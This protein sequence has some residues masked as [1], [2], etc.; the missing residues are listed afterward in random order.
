MRNPPELLDAALQY[1]LNYNPPLPVI[2]EDSLC[3]RFTHPLTIYDTHIDRRLALKRVKLVPTFL[4]DLAKAV[5]LAI[6][7]ATS[8]GIGLPSVEGHDFPTPESFNFLRRRTLP[9]DAYGITHLYRNGI[10]QSACRIASMLSLHPTAATWSTAVRM[11]I[12][13]TLRNEN[14]YTLVE[15]CMPE[16]LAP[17]K[18]VDEDEGIYHVMVDRDAWE[19]LSDDDRK[20]LEDMRKKFPSMAL[21]QMF[22]PRQETEDML[23][24][25]SALANMDTFPE[26]NP[27]TVLKRWPLNDASFTLPPDAVKTSWEMT[28]ASW[29]GAPGL[30]QTGDLLKSPVRPAFPLRRS[31]RTTMAKLKAAADLKKTEKRPKREKKLETSPPLPKTAL[32]PKWPNVGLPERRDLPAIDKDMT[33]SIIQ[34]AW[35][36]ALKWD[37]SFIIFHCGTFE[38]IAFRH[39][40]SQTLF[41]SDLIDITQCENPMYSKVQIGLFI[42]IINDVRDR[43]RQLI[44][45]EAK[46]MPKK[47]KRGFSPPETSKRPKTRQSA[48]LEET[49][50]MEDQRN[51]KAVCNSLKDRNLALLQI[52]HGPYNST[53]PSSFLRVD[54]AEFTPKSK[55]KPV[56]YFCITVTSELSWGATGDTHAAVIDFLGS[57]GKTLSFPHVVVKFA[58]ADSQKKR[59]RHEFHVYTH[60]MASGARGIPHMFG[61]F[62]DVETEALALVMEHVGSSLWDCR[63]PDKTDRLHITISE[64]ERAGYL[65][66]LSSIHDAGVRHRD[67]RIENL[68]INHE[69][70]PYIIDFDRAALGAN[71]S[72]LQ[73]E[74]EEFTDLLDGEYETVRVAEERNGAGR[75]GNVTMGTDNQAGM[76]A[77]EAARPG[78]ARYLVDKVLEG[79]QKVKK[80]DSSMI[81]RIYWTPGHA[82]IQGNEWADREAKQAAEGNETETVTKGLAFLKRSLSM[83]KAAVM[84]EH[85]KEWRVDTE[86]KLAQSSRFERLKTVDPN[87]PKMK[88]A[89]QLLADLPRKQ[90]SILV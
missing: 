4:K 17:Y 35:T 79:I 41:I 28:V 10:S 37:S 34:H 71:E 13:N 5:D 6:E 51:F 55:F 73:R 20:D 54:R 15:D 62:E 3:P 86:R 59:L 82:G 60:L 31:T 44:S 90:A 33:T 14:Y 70:N 84:A 81:V 65:D 19:A 75:I 52:R 47:R 80:I 85:K 67:L 72:S 76:K 9:K 26:I 36:R 38:R 50:K 68:T 27:L 48:A 69:G 2:Q 78:T 46:A 83:S 1:V 30:S 11:T 58:F 21:W 88:K 23:K 18:P 64:S 22:F 42:S 87:A 63:V 45:Q 8:D 61:L 77:L 66:A 7:K 40:S 16:I 56:D 43:T 24:D 32:E 74:Y 53:V 57:D 12:R 49:R 25:I 29:L 39:R 89:V